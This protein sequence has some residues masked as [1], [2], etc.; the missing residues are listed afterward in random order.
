MSSGKCCD[1]ELNPGGTEEEESQGQDLD[2]R[3]SEEKHTQKEG[4]SNNDENLDTGVVE[5]QEQ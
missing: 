4:E 5:N 1:T 3:G 2:A